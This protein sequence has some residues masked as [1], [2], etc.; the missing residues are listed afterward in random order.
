MPKCIVCK[1]KVSKIFL[2]LYTCKCKKVVCSKHKLE[3][4]CN[5]DYKNKNTEKLNRELV[6]LNKKMIFEI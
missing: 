5:Y 6:K 2:E 4:K 3:H 1:K